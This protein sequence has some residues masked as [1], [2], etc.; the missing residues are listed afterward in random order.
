MENTDNLYDIQITTVFRGFMQVWNKFEPTLSKEFA[1]IQ[2]RL[3]GMS[4]NADNRPTSTNYDIFY[5]AC[6]SI[7]PE[8]NITMGEFSS[9]LSVPLSTATR[10]ADWLVDKGFIQRMPDLDDRRIVRVSLTDTGKELYKAID[11]YIRQRLKNIL[12]NLTYEEKTILLTLVGK[13]LSGLKN[14]KE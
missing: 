11:Q 9:S 8:G 2:D 6:D 13:L 4:N 7:Y 12:L 1:Q 3:H 10:I 14:E 5:R